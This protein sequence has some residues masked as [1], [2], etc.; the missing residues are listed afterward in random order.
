MEFFHRSPR[1]WLRSGRN[2]Y[3]TRPEHVLGDTDVAV[4]LPA[5][6]L[7]LEPD[8]TLQTAARLAAAWLLFQAVLGLKGTPGVSLRFARVVVLNAALL[9][10]FAIVQGLTWNGRIYWVRPAP[11]VRGSWSAGG[12]FVSHSHLAA[13]L[14]MG[15]GLALGLLLQ[16]N[17]RDF[18]RRDSTKLWTAYA[19]GDHRRGSD[20]LAFAKRVPGFAGRQCLTCL[21]PAQTVD[22]SGVRA[23]S[24]AGDDRT[25]P[26]AHGRLFVLWFPSGDHPRRRQ[27]GLRESTRNMAGSTTGLVGSTLSGGPV[28][29]FFPSRSSPI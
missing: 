23:R 4:A 14:N 9:S 29:E 11:R 7:S 15:L 19:A 2:S 16:G 12:P 28:S 20:Q 13:Y 18:L 26:G 10:L 3:L 25:V 21:L 24:R 27:R 22:P 8:S 17:W 1:R 5:A 6:T